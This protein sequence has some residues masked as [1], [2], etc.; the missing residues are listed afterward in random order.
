M[1]SKYVFFVNKKN[2][3]KLVYYPCPK[4]ANSSAKLFF[5]RHLGIENKFLF[6]GDEKPRYLQDKSIYLKEN[7]IPLSNWLPSKQKFFKIDS[8]FKCCIVRD[9]VK[10]F[11]SAYKNRIIYHKDKNFFNHTVDEVIKKLENDKFENKHFLPQNYFLGNDLNYYDF[12]GHVD[13]I[14]AFKNY[15]NNFFGQ[16]LEFPSIQKGGSATLLDLSNIQ[17]NKIKKIY[18][19]DYKLLQKSYKI[20]M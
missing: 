10:R 2:N 11:L 7:K 1:S 8:D 15:I 4:N 18:K 17:K 13:N 5:A 6:L 16:H 9:P 3:K 19:F 14:L 12:V 20:N